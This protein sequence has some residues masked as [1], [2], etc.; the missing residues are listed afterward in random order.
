MNWICKLKQNHIVKCQGNDDVWTFISFYFVFFTFPLL[1]R[2]GLYIEPNKGNTPSYGFSLS[3]LMVQGTYL[4]LGLQD[5]E[6]DNMLV[7]IQY[8]SY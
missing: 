6:S 2:C 3:M 8:T 4:F 5:Y 1:A 7:I